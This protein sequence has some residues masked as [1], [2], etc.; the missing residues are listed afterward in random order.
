MRGRIE[1]LK[2]AIMEINYFFVEISEKKNL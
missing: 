2:T 1:G